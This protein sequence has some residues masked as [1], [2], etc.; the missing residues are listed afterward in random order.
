MEAPSQYFAPDYFEW[1]SARAERS[2]R[3]VVP[4]LVE[5]F[6]PTSVVDVGCGTGAWLQVFV[7]NGVEDVVGVDGPYIERGQL[8]IPLDRFAAAD[9]SA[10][11]ALD[12][13]FDLALSLEA[14]HYAPAG[15]APAI[16]AT[17][18]SLA[19]VVYFSAAIPYQGGG[20]GLNRQWPRYWS[21]LFAAHGFSCVDALRARLWEHPEVDWWYAQNGLVYM[22]EDRAAAESTG[23]PPALVH[24]QL[25]VEIAA[26]SEQ[27][28]EAGDGRLARLLRRR[29]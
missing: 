25:Y 22:R 20:P 5:L 1:Q 4:M 7:D 12:R 15:A 8:R 17:L 16:V 19:P 6:A 28:A 27:P 29:T 9:L 23:P 3:A 13:S 18:A 21:D 26:A 10:L 11:P 24:P 2:A 14:A